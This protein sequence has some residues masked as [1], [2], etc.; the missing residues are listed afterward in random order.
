MIPAMSRG[1]TPITAIIFVINLVLW[2]GLLYIKKVPWKISLLAF[3][4]GLAFIMAFMDGVAT[5]DKIQLSKGDDMLNGMYIM[6]QKINWWASAA[7][8][9]FIF[10]LLARKP[11]AQVVGL[12]AGLMASI[13]GYPLALVNMQETGR[14]SMF[15]PS[16]LL[17]TALIIVLLLPSTRALLAWWASG[18]QPEVLEP[19]PAVAT[20]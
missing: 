20:G 6:V 11:W 9:I 14:F 13:G 4:A 12:G 19:I 15:A 2:I 5:I 3:A 17:S 8:A 18:Q 1:E 16:P 10:V 7:W